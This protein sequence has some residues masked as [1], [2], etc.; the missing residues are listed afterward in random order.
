MSIPVVHHESCHRFA[1]RYAFQFS[2]VNGNGNPLTDLQNVIVC[3]YNKKYYYSSTKEFICI[4]KNIQNCLYFCSIR[5][6]LQRRNKCS[7]QL[8]LPLNYS[9]LSTRSNTE[10]NGLWK[11]IIFRNIQKQFL[12]IR[13]IYW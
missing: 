4:Y 11:R 8:K 10:I 9:R 6:G 7:F 5:G 3:I 13:N 12:K 2:V 1:E